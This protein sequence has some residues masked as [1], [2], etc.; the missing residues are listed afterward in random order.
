MHPTG[1]TSALGQPR[2]GFERILAALVIAAFVALSA[3]SIVHRPSVGFDSSLGL[4]TWQSME[5]GARFNH[6][7]MAGQPDL[8]ADRDKYLSDQSPGSYLLPALVSR[9]L[10]T[11]IGVGVTVLQIVG[12]GLGVLGYYLLYI[13]TFRFPNKV[14][15]GACLV[16]L[17]RTETVE[18]AVRYNGGILLLFAAT[19][20]FLISSWACL[21][22]RGIYLALLPLIFLAGAFL[23]LSFALIALSV[24]AASILYRLLKRK[25][26][27]QRQLVSQS[28]IDLLA[29]VCFYALLFL[30]HTSKG[31]TAAHPSAGRSPFEAILILSY[32]LAGI[33][34]SATSILS[35]VTS[36]GA[37]FDWDPDRTL[38]LFHAISVPWLIFVAVAA[39]AVLLLFRAVWVRV[40]HPEYRAMLLSLAMVHVVAL[41]SFFLGRSLIP[42]DRHFWPVS[43]LL[44]PGALLILFNM[45]S[46][47]WKALFTIV[48]CAQ[49]TFSLW[50]N[51][52]TLW[53]QE[54]ARSESLA[55]TFPDSSQ[56]LV[57]TIVRLD[58]ELTSGRNVFLFTEPSLA[59]LVQKNARLVSWTM[60]KTCYRN[61][62]S[63]DRLIIVL[64]SETVRESTFAGVQSHFPT[65]KGWKAASLGSDIVLCAGCNGS[66]NIP[67][68]V[69]LPSL[70]DAS[71]CKPVLGSSDHP[72]PVYYR[73][74]RWLGI[75]SS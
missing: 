34:T 55:I 10:R 16:L 19:P 14:A 71:F 59:L 30:F 69:A 75:P 51:R 50:A 12:I 37:P 47:Y 26:Y 40:I 1:P 13:H 61:V 36:F 67:S 68:M 2:A 63:L 48:V 29:F 70:A 65:A 39:L 9:L 64:P 44:L 56:E 35:S 46:T 27:T 62:G 72:N 4:L 60:F 33:L 18:H 22:K 43:A 5:R 66:E 45:R 17:L 32:S 20:W 15:L 74:K 73:L 49:L 41:S 42:E 54:S 28:T 53:F 31:W 24:T 52:Q 38:S 23:K 25:D 57:D 58:G 8:A 11:R 21:R 7:K 6:L 3:V